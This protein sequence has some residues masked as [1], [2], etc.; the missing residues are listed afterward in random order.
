M[1]GKA[2]SSLGIRQG[3][4]ERMAGGGQL[5]AM[6]IGEGRVSFALS[7]ALSMGLAQPAAVLFEPLLCFV[8]GRRGARAV[9]RLMAAGLTPPGWG[10]G[11]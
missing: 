1:D 10:S 6:E 4:E 2:S 3:S 11:S 8:P 7:P 5:F 9:V